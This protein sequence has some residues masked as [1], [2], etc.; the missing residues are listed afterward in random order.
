MMAFSSTGYN[1]FSYGTLDSYVLVSDAPSLDLRC[2]TNGSLMYR[3]ALINDVHIGQ[4][5]SIGNDTLREFV[6]GAN[7]QLHPDIMLTAGDC[8]EHTADNANHFLDIMANLS[9]PWVYVWGDHDWG[10]G[11]EGAML[12]AMGGNS[13]DNRAPLRSTTALT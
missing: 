8:F 13:K 12:N 10:S 7:T 4:T 2:S 11:F 3:I 9:C 6:S 5:D 1:D